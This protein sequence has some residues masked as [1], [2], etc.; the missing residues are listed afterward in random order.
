MKYEMTCEDGFSVQSKDKNE[1]AGMGVWHVMMA[2]PTKK[3]SMADM[4]KMV[5]PVK[6]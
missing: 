4:A 5:K 3:T 1:V 2:H 6:A